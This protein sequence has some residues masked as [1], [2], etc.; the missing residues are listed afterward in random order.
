MTDGH[1]DPKIGPQVYLGPIKITAKIC[2]IIFWIGNDP[3]S[4]RSEVFRKFI[5]YGTC[6][7]IQVNVPKVCNPLEKKV[8]D[9]KIY[10][11][12]LDGVVTFRGWA[13]RLGALECRMP[14]PLSPFL[15]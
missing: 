14:D 13:V 5:E 6:T 12:I 10:F 9:G 1:P 15:A 3:P 11:C 8:G 7:C 2:N 4:P